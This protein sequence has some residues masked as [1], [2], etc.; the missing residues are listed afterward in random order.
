MDM[1]EMNM[2][3]GR[4]G[5]PMM[6]VS[7]LFLGIVAGAVAMLFVAPHSGQETRAILNDKRDDLMDRVEDTQKKTR[8]QWMRMAHQAEKSIGH[9]ES[10]VDK[11]LTRL[12]KKIDAIQEAVRS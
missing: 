3:D 4:S 2:E 12:E 8:K 10:E 5:R 9:L 6:I 11:R 1:N 7:G